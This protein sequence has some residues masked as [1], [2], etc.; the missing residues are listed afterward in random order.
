MSTTTIISHRLAC[1]RSPI[2]LARSG[3]I[4]I[5]SVLL[6]LALQSVMVAALGGP[7]SGALI[8]SFQAMEPLL[9]P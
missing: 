5:L 6:W 9:T 1:P 3:P 7:S 2:S 8:G 4:L